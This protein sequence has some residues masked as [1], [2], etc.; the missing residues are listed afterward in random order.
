VWG[1]SGNWPFYMTVSRTYMKEFH[2]IKDFAIM[3]TIFSAFLYA[4]GYLNETV[5]LEGFHLNSSELAPDPSTAITLG[6]RYVFLNTFGAVISIT[7]VGPSLLLMIGSARE[8]FFV[9]LSKYDKLTKL[10]RR[11][12]DFIHWQKVRYILFLFLPAM[13]VLT[14]LHTIKSAS[15]KAT[16][17]KEPGSYVDT[18]SVKT[19]DGLETYEGKV[20]RIRDDMV[21]FWSLG[22]NTSRIF[23]NKIVFD[24]VYERDKI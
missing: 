2:I 17:F 18:I 24:I 14:C 20:V 3:A 4:L 11:F 16:V 6:F 12:T 13:A 22:E 23:P 10:Y 5:Y 1:G 9:L 19:P 7:I 21:L 15:D 8:D